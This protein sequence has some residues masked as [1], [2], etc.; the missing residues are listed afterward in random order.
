MSF[1]REALSQEPIRVEGKLIL[2]P[3]SLTFEKPCLGTIN[4]WI[5]FSYCLGSVKYRSRAFILS[6]QRVNQEKKSQMSTGCWFWSCQVSGS[7]PIA[8]YLH[9]F[10]F[11]L[12][13][14]NKLHLCLSHCKTGFILLATW[15]PDR[16]AL[17]QESHRKSNY[18][19]IVDLAPVTHDC[20]LWVHMKLWIPTCS[21]TC[22]LELWICVCRVVN[23]LLDASYDR[24]CLLF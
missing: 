5:L 18:S 16:L 2:C 23:M 14:K 9:I 3:I 21:C 20:H 15:S 10:F 17:P 6:S 4:F 7:R 1:V 13:E 22:V 12:L 19:S 11:L 8:T 24:S